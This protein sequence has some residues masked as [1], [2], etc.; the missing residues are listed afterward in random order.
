MC[1]IELRYHSNDYQFMAVIAEVLKV[2]MKQIKTWKDEKRQSMCTDE[3][4][5]K[6]S[7]MSYS[8]S[9][10]S[11]NYLPATVKKSQKEAQFIDINEKAGR[12]KMST[13]I[14][15]KIIGKVFKDNMESFQSNGEDME[16][17]INI[18]SIITKVLSILKELDVTQRAKIESKV[19]YRS[20]ILNILFTFISNMYPVQAFNQEI[21][22]K[23]DKILKMVR[24]DEEIL[25]LFCFIVGKRLIVIDDFEF[26]G[27]KEN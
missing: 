25:H 17:I 11:N 18:C 15:E 27:K 24:R 6:Q 3:E 26:E 12:D 2:A 7:E 22:S 8:S 4:E 16:P 10:Y 14:G 13:M 1:Y 20:D 19:L 5:A 23:H 21:F 9:L